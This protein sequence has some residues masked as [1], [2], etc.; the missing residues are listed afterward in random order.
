MYGVL[1]ALGV[2]LTDPDYT[3]TIGSIYLD[4]FLDLLR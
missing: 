2:E 3:K 1:K 4:L